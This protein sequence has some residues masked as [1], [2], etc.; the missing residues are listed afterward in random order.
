MLSDA[1][2]LERLR[3]PEGPVDAVLDTDA[4][5]EIDD[6]FALAY[7]IRSE[8]RLSLKA[9][10]AAP[11]HNEKSSGPADGME[12]SYHEILNILRLMGEEGRAGRVYR[13]S[14]AFLKDEKTAERSPAA[15]DLICRAMTS[16]PDAPLY[17]VAIGAITNVASAIL[18]RPEITER[19][20]VVW[21][22]GHALDWPDSL[23]FNLRQDVAAGRVVL[24]SGVP[25]VLVP[26]MGVASSFRL[27]GP[28]LEQHLRGKNALCDYLAD[29]TIWEA[30]RESGLA[31]W[32]RVIW[33]VC[34]AAWLSGP[35]FTRDRLETAPIP[36][37]D[38]H[39]ARSG[40]RHLIKYV[41]HIERDR[42]AQDLFDKLG[43]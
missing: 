21:L 11:F 42:L 1:R 15:L 40:A 38:H 20:V 31:A 35:D 22:G 6:Q 13:G 34:A 19:I 29:I 23:E 24:G 41:Y 7:L 39:Y 14:G 5:N 43:R 32:S 27:S 37:Y 28:E 3:R 12:K 9:V 30:A 10:Y 26:C 33:D 2:I 17:V 8:D 4:Y 36:E 25:L 18:L 16:P